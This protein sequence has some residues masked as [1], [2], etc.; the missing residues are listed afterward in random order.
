MSLIRDRPEYLWPGLALLAIAAACGD[1]ASVPYNAML[2]QISTPQNSGRISGFGLA[3]AFVG[4]VGLL[5]TTYFGCIVGEGD[6]RGFL[7]LPVSDGTNVRVAMLLAAGWFVVFALPLLLTAHRLPSPAEVFSPVRGVFGSYRKLWQDLVTEWHRD[8]NLVYY[9]VASAVFSRRTGRRLHLR[10][11]A[12]RQCVRD[13]TGRCADLRGGRQRGGGGRSRL[14]RFPGRPVGSKP[15]IIGS[16][17]SIIAAGLAMMA[18]SGPRAFWITG[19]LLVCSSARRRHR[20]GPAAED[21]QRRKRRRGLRPLHDDRRAVSFVAPW[22]FSVFVDVF[23]AVRAGM[24]GLCL[25]MMVGLLILLIVR[26]PQRI[27]ATDVD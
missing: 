25:V 4:S 1:L 8:R 21:V 6:T 23:G 27:L 20:R 2:R 16:L 7:Q 26:V 9:L 24:A 10:R 18:L 11:R 5:L 17:A 19:L 3:A 13:L 22:L 15:V 12:R 14:R